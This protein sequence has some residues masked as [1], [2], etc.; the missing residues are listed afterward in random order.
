MSTLLTRVLYRVGS[1][2]PLRHRQASVSTKTSRDFTIKTRHV[3]L[4]KYRRALPSSSRLRNHT[5][6]HRLGMHPGPD[7]RMSYSWKMKHRGSSRRTFLS[8][9][10]PYRIDV[11]PSWRSLCFYR[12]TG[13]I[14]FAP[15]KSRGVTKRRYQLHHP[16]LAEECIPPG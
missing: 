15:L 9:F 14:L 5:G 3:R 12:C 10:R 16:L 6:D 11:F 4:D 8:R 7:T 2:C 1:K 13:K